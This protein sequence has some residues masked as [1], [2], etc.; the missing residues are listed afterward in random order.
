MRGDLQILPVP[1]RRF[2]YGQDLYFYFEVG[3]LS[4]SEVGDYVWDEAYYVIPEAAGEGIVRIDPEENHTS[5]IPSA[6]RSMAIDLSSMAETYEGAVFLVVLVTDVISGQR[7]I[8]ATRF[9]LSRPP[10]P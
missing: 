1:S 5:L 10:Q 6:A 8:S 2:F 3:N 7:V 9:T 4:R